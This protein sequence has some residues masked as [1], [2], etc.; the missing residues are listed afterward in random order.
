MIKGHDHT[1]KEVIPQAE[2]VCHRLDFPIAYADYDTMKHNMLHGKYSDSYYTRP[3]S[4]AE[5]LNTCKAY[6]VIPIINLNACWWYKNNLPSILPPDRLAVMAGI[7]NDILSDNFKRYY[8]SIFNEPGKWLNTNQVIAYDNAVCSKVNPDVVISGND[9]F[10]MLGW[11][12]VASKC[13]AKNIGV[14]P[15]SSLGTWTE[16]KKYFHIIKDWKT[17]T[18]QYSKQVFATEAGSWFKPYTGEGHDINIDVINECAKYNYTGCLIVL[19]DINQ[20][21]YKNTFGYRVW[22]ND[23]RTLIKSNNFDKFISIFNKD[24]LPKGKDGM[25]IKTIGH[26]NTDIKSGYG[27]LLLNEILNYHGFLAD[28]YINFEYSPQTRK[29]LEDFQNLIKPRYNVTVDGRCGRMMWRYLLK[30]ILDATERKEF[31]EDFEIIMSPYNVNGD[32]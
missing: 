8:V 2:A 30:E 27:C 13:R 22:S 19:P 3:Y 18:A 21:N 6:N 26:K 20:A 32:T 7:L 4:L 29:A 10:N 12:K 9:E 5:I 11:H 25:I 28:D 17:I 24:K 31:R 14:H 15:L 1:T 23:Y 16:P